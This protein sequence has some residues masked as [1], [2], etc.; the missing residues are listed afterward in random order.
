M[1]DLVERLD[2][3]ARV[4]SNLSDPAWQHSTHQVEWF[5]E[6][7]MLM[8]EA[9]AEIERLRANQQYTCEEHAG[10]VRKGGRC[11][12]CELR[13]VRA[14]LSRAEE[15]RGEV[16][17]ALASFGFNSLGEPTFEAGYPDIRKL[18]SLRDRGA[19]L[20]GGS[21]LEEPKP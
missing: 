19:S 17:A 14:S 5:R 12:W 3:E 13:D 21:S 4:L 2:A 9:S 20:A 16:V 11:V 7:S 1:S 6:R 15:W 18:I 10:E 8:L